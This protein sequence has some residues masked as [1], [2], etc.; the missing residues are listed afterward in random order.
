MKILFFVC[1]GYALTGVIPFFK[2][3][4]LVM[5]SRWLEWWE[6]S[7]CWLFIALWVASACVLLANWSQFIG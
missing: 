2:F 1:L 5:E 4:K 3:I 6:I 7:V